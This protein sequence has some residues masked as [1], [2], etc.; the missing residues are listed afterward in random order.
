MPRFFATA[1]R[2]SIL[3]GLTSTRGSLL[4]S[5]SDAATVPA[6]MPG[7]GPP[8][9]YQGTFCTGHTSMNINELVSY[10][11]L[12][13]KELGNSKARQ[14]LLVTRGGNDDP[15]QPREGDDARLSPRRFYSAAQL[16]KWRVAKL[17]DENAWAP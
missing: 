9:T 8:R 11:A 13:K 14:C 12:I 7:I 17:E 2:A 6:A 15:A 4:A 5:C 10:S 16:R 3:G 1:R